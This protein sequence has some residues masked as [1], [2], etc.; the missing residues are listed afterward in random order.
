MN[1]ENTLKNMNK[2]LSP[3]NSQEERVFAEIN[4]RLEGKAT[5]KFG[6]LNIFTIFRIFNMKTILKHKSLSF[7]IVAGICTLMFVLPT[8]VLLLRNEKLSKSSRNEII[9]VVEPETGV[10]EIDQRLTDLQAKEEALVGTYSNEVSGDGQ[11][12]S[13]DSYY[14]PSAQSEDTE[15]P[16]EDRIKEQTARFGFE[17]KDIQ[18]D[19]ENVKSMAGEFDGYISSSSMTQATKNVRGSAR[20]TMRIPSDKFQFAVD[21]LYDMDLEIISEQVSTLDKQNQLTENKETKSSLEQEIKEVKAEIAKE[22]D[23]DKKQQLEWKLE[24]LE[25]QLEYTDESIGNLIES[26]SFSTISVNLSEATNNS[27]FVDWDDVSD[28]FS[29]VVMFWIQVTIICSVPLIILAVLLTLIYRAI[30][31]SRKVEMA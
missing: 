28:T 16:E 14:Y 27:N 7:L 3:T 10:D 15:T 25:Y 30:K 21:K 29:A 13:Q 1:I 18:N 31:K 9:D 11:A 8:G 2:K 5:R 23:A 24:N 17:S 22:T 26:T 12:S 6:K 19:F 4:S 20:V